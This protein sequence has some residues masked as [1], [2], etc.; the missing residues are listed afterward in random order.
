MLH[1]TKKQNFYKSNLTQPVVD[2]DWIFDIG[3]VRFA[4]SIDSEDPEGIFH[5]VGQA[6]HRVVEVRTLLRALIGWNPLHSSRLLV[7]NKVA[8]YPALSIMAGHFPLQADR[9]LGLIIS[10]RSN[11]WAG[12]YCG[13]E[14]GVKTV[15]YIMVYGETVLEKNLYMFEYIILLNIIVL[16]F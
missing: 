10:L 11:W 3:R 2:F 6:C 7:F 12:T 1:L 16:C 4:S 8:K 15:N 5:S 14:T 13:G 9:V